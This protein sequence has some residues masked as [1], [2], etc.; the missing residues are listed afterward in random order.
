M[1]SP[2]T[3]KKLCK[4]AGV[5]KSDMKFCAELVKSC[6]EQQAKEYTRFLLKDKSGQPF[7]FDD[8]KGCFKHSLLFSGGKAEGGEAPEADVPSPATKP[9]APSTPKDVC[10]SAGL[11]ASQEANCKNA[12]DA[13]PSG[14]GPFEIKTVRMKTA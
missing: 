4:D 11:S 12:A 7:Y 14:D 1:S 5:E 6:E 2:K 8:Y 3:I 10:S 9:A 13:C